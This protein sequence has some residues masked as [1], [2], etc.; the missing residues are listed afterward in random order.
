VAFVDN[1]NIHIAHSD[2][3]YQVDNST[4]IYIIQA[5]RLF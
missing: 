2:G 3:Q 4:N 5:S 1:N